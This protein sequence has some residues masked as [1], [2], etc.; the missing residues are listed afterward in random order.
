[1]KVLFRRLIKL[2]LVVLALWAGGFLWFTLTLPAAPPANISATDGIVVL[3][4]GRGR[5]TEGLDLLEQKKGLRLLISGVNLEISDALLRDELVGVA[6]NGNQPSQATA[7]TSGDKMAISPA[8]YDCCVDLGRVALDTEGNAREIA[9]WAREHRYKTIR[10]VTG[11]YHMPR[12][13]VELRQAA[14][15]LSLV[16]HPVF[17]ANVKLQRWWAYPGTSR[18][19]AS[20]YNKY[21][22]SLIRA[23][24]I[25]TAR[26]ATS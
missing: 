22:A 16:P 13:L 19:L 5:L 8:L 7:V 12:S 15:G 26:E 20:E 21:T 14:P 25:G 4:G 6:S 23:R 18:M 9:G 3:T 10:V 2:T 24:L 11:A 1:M 17:T